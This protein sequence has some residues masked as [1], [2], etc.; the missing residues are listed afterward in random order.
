MVQSKIFPFMLFW[1]F[2]LTYGVENTFS[3]SLR[4]VKVRYS[5]LTL[6]SSDGYPLSSR[7]AVNISSGFVTFLTNS[8]EFWKIKTLNEDA[9]P[10]ET[11][12]SKPSG[13]N[14]MYRLFNLTIVE[15]N[16]GETVELK[17]ILPDPVPIGSQW[18]KVN[19]TA[20]N[21]T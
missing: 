13:L 18:W 4:P 14:V 8:G 6:T 15:L 10:Q 19:L 11:R 5:W 2:T 20:G 16:L 3:S 17:L 9:L 7:A 1:A 21:N 12:K